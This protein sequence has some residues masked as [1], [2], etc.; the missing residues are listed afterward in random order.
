MQKRSADED[1]EPE[2]PRSPPK[3][4]EPEPDLQ[5]LKSDLFGKKKDPSKARDK[6]STS[7]GGAKAS[8]SEELEEDAARNA[9]FSVPPKREKAR[10]EAAPPEEEDE[11]AL[12][13]ALFAV[14][15]ADKAAAASKSRKATPSPPPDEE[16][17]DALRGALFAAAPAKSKPSKANKKVSY[18]LKCCTHQV[19]LSPC[20]LYMTPIM[21]AMQG[22]ICA[23]CTLC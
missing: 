15:K 10:K 2:A 22:N 4:K 12:R 23:V 14:P 9:L 7:K 1:E 5:D 6:P 17:E 21:L 19:R 16:D 11:D 20:I 3:P 8:A 18:K 13:G